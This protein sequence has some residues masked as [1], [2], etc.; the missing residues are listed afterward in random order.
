MQE[1]R[2]LAEVD[3]GS[4]PILQKVCEQTLGKKRNLN[5]PYA[6]KQYTGGRGLIQHKPGGPILDVAVCLIPPGAQCFPVNESEAWTNDL[7]C[8]K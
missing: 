4:I 6:G 7:S 3:I 8:R 2:R 5:L 1:Q